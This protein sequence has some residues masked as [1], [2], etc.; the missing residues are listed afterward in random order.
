MVRTVGLSRLAAGGGGIIS[1][2]T[3]ADKRVR[4]QTRRR[5][6]GEQRLV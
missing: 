6:K 5:W 3:Y 1:P 4:E 2:G